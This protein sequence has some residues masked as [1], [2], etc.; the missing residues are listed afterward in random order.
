MGSLSL[1]ARVRVLLDELDGP[2]GMVDQVLLG[3]LVLNGMLQLSVAS[4]LQQHV[5][6]EVVDQGHEGQSS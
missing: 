3:D 2:V 5:G 4:L 1:Y 6:E